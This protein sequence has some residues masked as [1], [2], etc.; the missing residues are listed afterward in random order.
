MTS[1]QDAWSPIFEQRDEATEAEDALR[2]GE[3]ERGK[4]GQ[5]RTQG[6]EESK[7]SGSGRRAWE[8]ERDPKDGRRRLDQ[9]HHQREDTEGIEGGK[10][11]REDAVERE[12]EE[13]EWFRR[14]VRERAGQDGLRRGKGEGEEHDSLSALRKE[15]QGLSRKL[16]AAKAG[17]QTTTNTAPSPSLP[18]NGAVVLLL[19]VVVL[20]LLLLIC[21][22]VFSFQAYNRL[23]VATEYLAWCCEHRMQAAP[24]YLPPQ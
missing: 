22:L 16:A 5:E 9:P 24:F 23:R 13:E 20:G 3:R 21:S 15:V 6:G 18:G 11:E 2:E 14:A 4:R 7:T 17:R 1:F 8:R 19:S 10:R 12:K